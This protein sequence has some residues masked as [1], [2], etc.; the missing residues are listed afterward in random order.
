MEG[1]VRP[2]QWSGSLGLKGKKAQEG[3]SDRSHQRSDRLGL[4]GKLFKEGG[5]TPVMVKQASI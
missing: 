1:G 3:R 2:P 5:Y 4:K